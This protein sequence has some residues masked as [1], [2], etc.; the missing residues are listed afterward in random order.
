MSHRLRVMLSKMIAGLRRR[1][2]AELADEV[3]HHL[4]L[5]EERYLARGM[6]P[7]AAHREARR[8]FGGVQQL[9]EAHREIR[10]FVWLDQLR[11]DAAYTVRLLRRSPGF[12]AVAILTLA[13]GIG[14]NAAVFSVVN[15]VVLQPLPYPDADRIQRIGWDWN[16]RGQVTG[17]L[18]PYKFDYLRRSNIT[19]EALATWRVSTPDIGA[20]GAGG[21]VTVLHVSED[22]FRVVGAPAGIG[23]TFVEDE[24]VPDR[25]TTAMLTDACWRSRFGSDAGIVGR[26]ILIDDRPH[27]VVGVMPPRFEFPEVTARADVLVP[28]ALRPDPSDLGANYPVLGRMRES[29][30]LGDVV[31]DVARVFGQL[32]AEH[33]AQFS[34]SDERA[35]VMSFNEMHL[36]GVEQPLWILFGGVSLVLLIACANVANLVMARAS[37]RVREMAV[38][39]ALGASRGRI[40]R[41]GLTEGVVL[42]SMG[43]ALGVVTGAVALRALSDLAP[44]GIARIDQVRIDGVVLMFMLAIVF[45]TGL[46]FGVASSLYGSGG[47]IGRQTTMGRQGGAGSRSGRRVRQW[48]IAAETALAMVLLAGAVVLTFG[49][50]RLTQ[51]DLGFDR[52]G[53]TVISFRRLPSGYGGERVRAFEREWMRRIAHLPGVTAVASTSMAPLGERGANIPMT[54]QGRPDATE[55][56][57]EWRAVSRGYADVM[58]LRIIRGRWLSESDVDSQR[59]V[60]VVSASTAARYWPDVDPIGQRILLGVFRGQPRPGSTP[61]ASEVIG[62]VDDVRELG[63][64]RPP[65]RMVFIPQVTTS[66]MPT[67]LIRA[68]TPLGAEVVRAVV[69]EVDPQLPEPALSTFDQRLGARLARDRFASVVIGLFAAIALALTA[70]GVYG[71]V[72]WVVRQ[73]TQEIGIRMALGANRTRVFGTVFVRGLLPV[74]A[75]LIVGG[76][77]SLL[78]TR[79]FAALASVPLVAGGWMPF[80]AASGLL[81]VASVAAWIP[82][83]RAMAVDPVVAIRA[84]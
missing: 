66:A 8:A 10:S 72:S 24:F 41:Q 56:A 48:L 9:T 69:R 50:Y 14:A 81:V 21:P 28:L 75:G 51:L 18:A 40:L 19:F 77:G 61:V 52:H 59:P 34:G 78:T 13:L 73:S 36:T 23:R 30:T 60:I 55:G 17:A 25:A 33:A 68:S 53:V 44:A 22:F 43:G 7:D 29:A 57:V 71:V 76:G 63:P 74:I 20:R 3:T 54:V 5:L 82:A 83:R 65:R 62:V 15:A 67:F 79:I 39:T 2:D 47:D 46:T 70:I 4:A 45:A 11:Q 27:V 6:T 16:G 84:E 38:R 37:A 26:T 32:R 80:A 58:G 31:R 1:A 64:V 49:F 12:S 35:V 42:A